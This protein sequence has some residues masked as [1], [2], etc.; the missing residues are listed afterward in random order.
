M[1]Y[2]E[3]FLKGLG[4]NGVFNPTC[5]DVELA[6]TCL[7]LKIP[8]VGVVMTDFHRDAAKAE[9]KRFL[10]LEYQD[11]SGP[12]YQPALAELITPAKKACPKKAA[13]KKKSKKK[14]DGG[15]DEEPKKDKEEEETK[16]EGT[17]S[18]KPKR[19]AGTG[20]ILFPHH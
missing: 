20:Y 18:G 17:A 2:Y 6:K 13:T 12:L 9:L 15:D 4:C 19:T 10:F 11:E 14:A 8:F 1:A 5:L 7:K 16:P 3:D